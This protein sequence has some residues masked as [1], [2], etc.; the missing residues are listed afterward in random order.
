MNERFDGYFE[1]LNVR[2]AP[3]FELNKRKEV[4]AELR[5]H[6]TYGARDA[7]EELGLNLEEATRSA[8]RS[9]GPVETVAEDLVR[10]HRGGTVKSPWRLL[11]FVIALYVL[12]AVILPIL[13][14]VTKGRLSNPFS[15][16]GQITAWLPTMMLFAFGFAVWR[17]RRWLVKPM[18]TMIAAAWVLGTVLSMT[19][20]YRAMVVRAY[21]MP[22]QVQAIRLKEIDSM[23]QMTE[24]GAKGY[25]E[26]PEKFAADKNGGLYYAPELVATNALVRLPYMPVAVPVRQGDVVGLRPQTWQR[27][28]AEQWN[29]Y[30]A[31]AR[32]R[33]LTDR[34]AVLAGYAGVATI[35]GITTIAATF[36]GQVGILFLVNF[37][38]LA[39]SNRRRRRRINRDPHLA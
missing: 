2:L 35:G 17:S 31:E 12:Q 7:Q 32:E 5:S 10:Q 8:L 28:R 4:I 25:L 39:A 11:R 3:H 26:S 15:T 24:L 16:I 22:P 9:L 37:G 36:V 20:P 33:L 38:V 21:Q 27:E 6:A 34:H 29:R 19:P 1:D 18:T 14:L 13:E 23:L 30:G